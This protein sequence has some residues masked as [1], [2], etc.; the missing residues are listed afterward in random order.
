M[1]KRNQNRSWYFPDWYQ[2]HN[3]LVGKFEDQNQSGWTE[4]QR[5]HTEPEENQI[6]I[7]LWYDVRAETKW[8]CNSFSG[9]EAPLTMIMDAG[10][11]GAA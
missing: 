6:Q 1:N 9:R 11:V 3:V 10:V 5:N 4:W 8:W 2:I 7:F